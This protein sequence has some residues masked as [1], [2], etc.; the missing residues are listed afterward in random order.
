MTPEEIQ[1]EKARRQREAKIA[2]YK[3]LIIDLEVC[4][5]LFPV[6]NCRN[7]CGHRENCPA[8]GRWKARRKEAEIDSPAI[9][10]GSRQ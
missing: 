1:Q 2:L 6:V 3:E 4:T 5:C 7:M 9:S 8:Y 10:R